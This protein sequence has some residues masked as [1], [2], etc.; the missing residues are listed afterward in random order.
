M[1]LTALHV[2]A[3][4]AI[5]PTMTNTTKPT[6]LKKIMSIFD[7]SENAANVIYNV[8]NLLVVFA[9]IVGGT[10]AIGLF[11]SGGVRE[12]YADRRAS[13]NERLTAQA[14]E[15]A[16]K[17]NEGLAK[18][19]ERQEEIRQENLQLSLKLE[20]EKNARSVLEKS[21]KDRIIPFNQ[22]KEAVGRFRGMEVILVSVRNR[23]A[24]STAEQLGI[25]LEGA[26]WKVI[27]WNNTDENF[28]SG[29]FAEANEAPS[30]PGDR[31]LQARDA[32]IAWLKK[33]EFKA[34]VVGGQRH[35]IPA[36]VVR[37]TVGP[38]ERLENSEPVRIRYDTVLNK[39]PQDE[40]PAKDE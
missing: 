30:Q 17:A 36:G 33:N 27:K 11:W 24:V 20:A 21:L 32:V 3:T 2:A 10:G 12:K 25:A 8:S 40:A 4:R 22:A 34:G 37:I 14:N 6:K 5:A 29:V 28:V 39:G 38:S 23:E 1:E 26:G 16:A 35:G 19:N 15:A 7:I 9:A 13:D 18:A 31:S